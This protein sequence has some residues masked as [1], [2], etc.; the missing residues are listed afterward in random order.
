M[1][2]NNFKSSSD[3]LN[4]IK[5]HEGEDI[6][7]REFLEGFGE[8]GFALFLAIFALPVALPLPAL[9]IASII[10]IP[11]LFL[12]VQLVLGF[13]APW[14][15]NWIGRKKIRMETLKKAIDMVTPILKKIE[16]FL[17]PRISFLSTRTGEKLIGLFCVICSISVALP[18]PFTN[19]LPSIGIVI[20]AIGLLERD[21][22][23]II[24]G[25]LAGILGLIAIGSL[26]YFGAEAL[27]SLIYK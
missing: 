2:V 10:A 18:F 20:M 7:F 16:R 4:D 12:S 6:T 15:P 3:L 22:I 21:G 14:V 23:V 5:N 11:L 9:G 26:Y 8:G 24:S 19:T 27:T 25:M 17:R 1:R 13:N